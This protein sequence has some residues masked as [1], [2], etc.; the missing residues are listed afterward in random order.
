MKKKHNW[1]AT[2]QDMPEGHGQSSEMTGHTRLK[3]PVRSVWTHD[4]KD[5]QAD[6]FLQVYF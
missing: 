3:I 1:I 5:G 6:N 2:V 4:L